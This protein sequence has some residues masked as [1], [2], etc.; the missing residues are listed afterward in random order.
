M[1]WTVIKRITREALRAPD[2][3]LRDGALKAGIACLNAGKLDDARRHFSEALAAAPGNFDA[4]FHLGLTEARSGHLDAAQQLLEAARARRDDAGVHNALG[5]IHRLRGQ[6]DAAVAGYRRALEL[7]GEHIAAL[8]NLGLSLRDQGDPEQALPILEHALRLAPD[9]V[10]A[11]F[12]TALASIDTGAS[13]AAYVLLGRVLEL[14]ADHAE[15]HTQRG[16]LLLRRGDFAA[17]WREYAWR[18]RAPDW[19]AQA[20]YSY[21]H[22]QGESLSGK[23]VLVRAEQGLGDQIMFASCLPEVLSQARHTVIEC[24]PRLAGLFA[25]SFP[26]AAVYRYRV[27]G[28]PD[29]LPEQAPDFQVHGGSLPGVLRNRTADFPR[30]RG[31]LVPDPARVAAWRARLAALGPGLNIGI[32]WRGGTPR[33]RQAARSL[34]LDTLLPILSLPQANFVSL[35]YDPSSDEITT[36]R[37]RHGVTIHEWPQKIADMDETAALVA[38][39][40]LVITVCTTVAHMSGALAKT[41]WVMVPVVAEWRYLER[42][43]TIPWYPALRLFRQ[44]RRGE[45]SDVIAAVHAELQDW[46]GTPGARTRDA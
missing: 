3:D 12:N 14:D 33:T 1:L 27:S 35:Q 30:H 41:A 45:W 23:S 17:G 16:F 19:G 42:G 37:V 22:W 15:A 4:L 40:D 38:S 34:T 11:L 39:L 8:V 28:E 24:D 21:P 13:E 36:Q 31:Y 43:V 10:D 32:A 9:H 5:N 6:L 25:R 7:D 26:A 18:M 2:G 46:A 29:W 20:Q 44:Q